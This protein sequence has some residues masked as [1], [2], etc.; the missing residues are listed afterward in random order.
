M[1]KNYKDNWQNKSRCLSLFPLFL[2][3]LECGLLKAQT[4]TDVALDMGVVHTT[5]SMDASGNSVS[6]FDFDNDGWDDLTFAAENDSLYLFRNMGGNAFER[7]STG[8]YQEGMTKHVLWVDYD[9][10]GDFDLFISTYQGFYRLFNNDGNLNFVDV[11]FDVGLG[12]FMGFNFGVSFG[13]VNRDGHLDIYL[14]KFSEENTLY[15]NRGDGT[16]EK[17]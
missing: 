1:K 2:W 15:L 16:F 3:I 9:N 10:D 5:G 11:T 7:L 4:F 17:L 6:F 13:D 14:S 8:I 12:G